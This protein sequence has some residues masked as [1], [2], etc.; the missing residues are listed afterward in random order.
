MFISLLLLQIVRL[1]HSGKAQ[2]K[3]NKSGHRMKENVNIIH[4]TAEKSYKNPS[5]PT[6]T[7]CCSLYYDPVPDTWLRKLGTFL[8]ALFVRL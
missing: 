1:T 5:P 3:I 7:L 4:I 8:Y 6:D 2:Y